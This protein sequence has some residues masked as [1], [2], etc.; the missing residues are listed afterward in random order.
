M[1]YLNYNIGFDRLPNKWVNGVPYSGYSESTSSIKTTVSQ[2]DNN[3]K[4]KLLLEQNSYPVSG[5][6]VWKIPLLKNPSTNKPLRMNL[7]MWNYPAASTQGHKH[8]FY[9]II[10]EYE[11]VTST[12]SSLDYDILPSVL[13]NNKI[14]S[15]TNSL[16]IEFNSFQPTTDHII[17]LKILSHGVGIIDFTSFSAGLLV[18]PNYDFYFF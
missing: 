3:F 1:N 14:A 13:P 5:L 9:E 6:A 17:E 10:N 7:T 18:V 16:S 12:P 11:T 2:S 15:S 8:F 4:I